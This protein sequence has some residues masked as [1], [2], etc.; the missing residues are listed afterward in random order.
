VGVGA[1]D[2]FCCVDGTSWRG[3]SVGM[4]GVRGVLGMDD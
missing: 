3:Q 4:L 1:V 2:Y